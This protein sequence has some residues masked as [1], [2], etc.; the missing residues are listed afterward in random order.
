VLASSLS[1]V[2]PNAAAKAGFTPFVFPHSVLAVGGAISAFVGVEVV[3]GVVD[4]AEAASKLSR[5]RRI[6]SE[7]HA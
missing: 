4:M 6:Q 5:E 1:E 7:S 3:K 2:F